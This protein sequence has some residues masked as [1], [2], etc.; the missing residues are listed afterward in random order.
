VSSLPSATR[1]LADVARTLKSANAGA[2]RL[3]F[4]MFFDH[5][6]DLHAALAVLTPTRVAGLYRVDPE[7]VAVFAVES[8][9][10]IKITIPRATFF[11]STEERDFDGVQQHVHLLDVLI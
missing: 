2:S 4:D 1:R 3:T 11:G 8:V 6:D 9:L 10:A 7:S 5:A